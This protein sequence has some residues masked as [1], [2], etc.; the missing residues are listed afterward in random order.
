MKKTTDWTLLACFAASMAAI[1]IF[2]TCTG[3]EAY[4]DIV[5]SPAPEGCTTR[6]CKKETVLATGFAY[7]G[8]KWAGTWFFCLRNKDRSYKR[9]DDKTPGVAHR[10]RKCGS[11]VKITNRRTGRTIW[12]RVIDR[13]PY[14]VVRVE[15]S[16]DKVDRHGFQYSSQKCWTKFGRPATRFEMRRGNPKAGWVWA[17]GLDM[18]PPIYKAIGFNGREPVDLVWQ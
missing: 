2:Q 18:T 7:K 15:C 6:T 4:G 1:F 12:A 16:E 5:K 17:N 14:W 10:W 8:D 3:N 9:I 11:R 13:G